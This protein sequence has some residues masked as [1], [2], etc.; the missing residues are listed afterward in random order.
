[1]S[2]E[3]AAHHPGGMCHNSPTFQRWDRDHPWAQVPKGRLKWCHWSAVPSGL[4]ARS[5][6]VPNVETLGYSRKSL[7][8]KDA[9]AFCE[10][11]NGAIPSVNGLESPRSEHGYEA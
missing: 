4:I 8:D 11:L 10:R 6:G 5:D 3:F 1:M 2:L 7:R 9:P